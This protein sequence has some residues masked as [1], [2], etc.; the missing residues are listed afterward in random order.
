[1]QPFSA[2]GI[3]DM[4]FAF[5]ELLASNYAAACGTL[6]ATVMSLGYHC[7][8]KAAGESEKVKKCRREE[9]SKLQVR[10]RKV[11]SKYQQDVL[12]ERKKREKEKEK[13]KEV[14]LK[15]LTRARDDVLEERTK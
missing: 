12:E 15:E 13:I 9:I 14:H 6:G 4:V 3:K 7:I 5:R 11:H 1:M 2:N 8:V 10:L